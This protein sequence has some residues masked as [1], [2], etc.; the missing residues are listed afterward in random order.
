[1]NRKF[2][3]SAGAAALGLALITTG[4]AGGDGGGETTSLTF[5][6][7]GGTTQDHQAT[8]FQEPFTEQTGITFNNDSPSEL[9][10]LQAMVEAGNVSWDV[11]LVTPAVANQFCGTL[12]EEIDSGIL[13]DADLIDGVSG[14]DC[15]VPT[16]TAQVMFVY[17]GDTYGAEQPT[18]IAD[19]FDTEKYPG[20]RMLPPELET[21]MLELAL[22]ADGVP[23]EELYPLDVDRAL[24]KLDTIK[25]S[26]VFADSYGQMEQAMSDGTI[27]MALAPETRFAYV[28]SAGHS[29]AA[30][31]DYTVVSV[32]QAAIPLGSPNKDAAEEF[33]AFMITPEPQATVAQLTTHGAVVTGADPDFD[34]FQQEAIV[35]V[36]QEN[37]G[38][39]VEF[40]GEWWGQNIESVTDQYLNWQMG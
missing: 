9:A 32:D 24:A 31:W 18:T 11:V 16:Y 40:D 3:L 21:G 35:F 25:D 28:L 8:G 36:D 22:L 39:I 1:M 7:W 30:V 10:K 29:W 2:R 13:A 38:E 26:L 23:L 34:E 4:C 12:F 37:R 15:S 19:F 27:D 33:L 14:T 5:V 6:G 17:N 20:Q